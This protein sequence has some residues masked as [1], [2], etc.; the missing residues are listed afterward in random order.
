MKPIVSV[1]AAL[2]PRKLRERLVLDGSVN[3]VLINTVYAAFV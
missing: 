1:V 3:L 2:L